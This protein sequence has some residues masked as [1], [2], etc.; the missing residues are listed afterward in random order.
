MYYMVVGCNEIILLG[1][2][3]N[4]G[5]EFFMEIAMADK[6]V[7]GRVVVLMD[8][9]MI[10]T[11]GNEAKEERLYVVD[12]FLLLAILNTARTVLLAVESLAK[13]DRN[14]ALNTVASNCVA[15]ERLHENVL[16]VLGMDRETAILLAVEQEL[17][18]TRRKHA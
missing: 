17:K 7:D 10:R 14:C 5:L 18:Q 11:A 6:K 16:E 9:A 3:H 1:R 4:N 2:K 12:E 15:A 13:G 8:A